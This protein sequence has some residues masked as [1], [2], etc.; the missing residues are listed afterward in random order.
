MRTI[1]ANFEG[2]RGIQM[3]SSPVDK[4]KILTFK[5]DFNLENFTTFKSF[6]FLKTFAK[7]LERKMMKKL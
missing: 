7:I 6:R 2:F 3:H 5:K 4:Q 1:H